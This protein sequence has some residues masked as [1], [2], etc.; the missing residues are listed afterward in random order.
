MHCNVVVLVQPP[1]YGPIP[2]RDGPA[3][4]HALG[5]RAVEIAHAELLHDPREG[6]DG[7][8]LIFCTAPPLI[9]AAAEPLATVFA[10]S[11]VFLVRHRGAEPAQC[12]WLVDIDQGSLIANVGLIH[13]AIEAHKDWWAVV[14]DIHF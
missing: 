10:L 2:K 4:R 9:R 13:A 12:D 11:G 5:K 1:T 8:G 7:A 14:F 3:R 6:V